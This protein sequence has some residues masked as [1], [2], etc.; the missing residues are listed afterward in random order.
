MDHDEIR[1]LLV[2]L[3]TD[4]V[5]RKAA[6]SDLDRISEAIC[7]F[8]NDL[9][10]HRAEGIVAVGVDDKTGAPTGLTVD[11]DLLLR[12]ASLRDNGKIYPFPSMNV[13]RI[14]VDGTHIA[15][16]VVA[17]SEAPPVQFRG[18]TWIRVGPRRAIATPAEEIRLAERRRAGVL[19][20]D[21]SAVNGASTN[22]LALDRFRDELLP[23][24]VAPDVL[25][26]NHRSL[27]VQ[28]SSLRFTDPSGTPTPTGLLVT[29]LDP[30]AFLPGAYVQFLRV[31][32]KTL[33]DPVLSAHR[34]TNTIT[35]VIRELE[36]TLRAHVDTAVSFVGTNRE[37]RR[38]NVP[39]EA[40]QQLV[41]N[42]LIHRT[43]EATNAPVRITWFD[44]RV[45][46]QS[47]GGP[48]GLVAVDTFGE[49]GVTDYRNPTLAGVLAQLGF[50]QRFGVGIQVAR[51]VLDANGNPPLE[52]QAT[53]THVN[54]VVRFP[55]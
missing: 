28:L 13:E 55:R 27:E 26:A 42:A 23:Q 25:A 54:A 39:I 40:L 11:D 5:E 6:A 24:L 30:L 44:D 16:V 50:V 17:P 7:A 35:D 3:E 31:E 46:I 8:A 21:A 14:D 15:V 45:E 43:Y 1:R 12:L 4:R 32:G 33:A 37:E 41:R 51:Q 10:G 38:P 34:L 36:E 52:L 18:R 29:G 47:P 19:P 48:F 22:D 20:F 53:P 9:P 2:D 49:P